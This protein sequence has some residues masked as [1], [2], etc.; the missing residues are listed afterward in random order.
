MHMEQ[1]DEK[2]CPSIWDQM[3]LLANR[4]YQNEPEHKDYL[5]HRVIEPPSLLKAIVTMVSE[6]LEVPLRLLESSLTDE[7]TDKLTEDVS[8]D[9]A[10]YLE[11][12]PAVE[13]LLTPCL[14]HKGFHAICAYRI[15]NV[16]WSHD[17]KFAARRIQ[18]EASRVY[19]VD[20][21]P[22]ARLGKAIMLDH[23]TGFVVGETTVIK[24]RVSIMQGVTL[25]GTGKARGDRHP[26]IEPGVLLSAGCK[27]LGNIR[28]GTGAKVA[29]G[30][31]V[32]REVAP[33]TT[34]AGIPAKLVRK[35]ADEKFPSR[36]MEHSV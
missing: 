2:T 24:D 26:K 32:L 28:V 17:K 33:F 35:H 25:G 34:V 12:D 7:L 16:L 19:A 31:V 4:I 36:E 3:R 20:I 11:R 30:S 18:Y 29:A 1:M 15:A 23:A 10:A 21:H 8:A 13:D 9:L 22:A 27:V 5:I 14:F 6:H